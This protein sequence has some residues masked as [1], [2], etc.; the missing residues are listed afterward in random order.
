MLNPFLLAL[1]FPFL[2]HHGKAAESDVP[3]FAQLP[4]SDHR[5]LQLC[6]FGVCFMCSSSAACL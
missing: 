3:R 4:W 2:D 1:D 6:K 5:A